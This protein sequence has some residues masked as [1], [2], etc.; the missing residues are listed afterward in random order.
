M[1]SVSNIFGSLVQQLARRHAQPPEDL[2]RL[3]RDH[4]KAHT[5]PSLKDLRTMLISRLSAYSQSFIILDALDETDEKNGNR[6][7]LIAEL[8]FLSKSKNTKVLITSRHCVSDEESFDPSLRVEIVA[9]K[10]DIVTYVE[11]R[12]AED[13]SRLKK[14]FR[15]EP[16]LEPLV[17]ENVVEKAQGM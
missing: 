11:A 8:K 10:D 3:Y 16:R 6:V 14:H 4:Q 17:L 1:Q 15:N 9:P 7:K 5:R 12:I 2:I 13:G